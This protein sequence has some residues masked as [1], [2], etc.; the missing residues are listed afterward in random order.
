MIYLVIIL[1]GMDFTPTI[2]AFTNIKDAKAYE[3][4]QNEFSLQLERETGY[5]LKIFTKEIPWKNTKKEFIRYA[6]HYLQ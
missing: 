1:D 6:N 5:E 2:K 4:E 3:I